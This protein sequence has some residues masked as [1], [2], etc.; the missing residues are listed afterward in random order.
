L[1]LSTVEHISTFVPAFRCT[2]AL[3]RCRCNPAAFGA[4]KRDQSLI[5]A[6]LNENTKIKFK[7]LSNK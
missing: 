5:G 2:S 1:G 4:G 7:K 3:L 6:T